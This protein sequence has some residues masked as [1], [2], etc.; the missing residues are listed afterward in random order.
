LKDIPILG[1]SSGDYR[2]EV[3]VEKVQKIKYLTA[4]VFSGNHIKSWLGEI[5]IAREAL[6]QHL[7][8]VPI[9]GSFISGFPMDS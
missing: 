8:S 4:T 3:M 5:F 6:K 2:N 9:K 7:V 1:V